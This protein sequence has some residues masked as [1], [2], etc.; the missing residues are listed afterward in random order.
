[1]YDGERVDDEDEIHILVHPADDATHEAS[2]GMMLGHFEECAPFLGH[3]Y[4]GSPACNRVLVRE[5]EAVTISLVEGTY[6]F[7]AVAGPFSTMARVG[8]VVVEAG[9]GQSVDLQL[10]TI[11]GLQPDGTLSGDFHIHARSSFDS[12]L[13]DEDRMRAVLASKI[14]VIAS[15]EHDSVFDFG[16]TLEDLGATGKVAVMN[17]TES[18]GHVLWY[19]NPT[20]TYPQVT[21]HWITWP[22]P[23]DPSQPWQGAPWDEQV[24]PGMLFTRYEE[25]GWDPE[26]GVIQLNHPVG[27]V[28]FG[29]DFGWASAML[30]S[31]REDLGGGPESAQSLFDR[32]PEGAAFAND[33]YHAQEVMN[34]TNNGQFL[35][36]RAYWHYLLNQ[37]EVRAGTANSDSHTLTDN[38]VGTPR[39]VVFTDTTLADFDEAS[40]N[41]SVREGRMFGTNGPVLLATLTD[42]GV[43]V[44][45]SS[46]VLEPSA[47]ASLD[48]EVRA[49]PWVDVQEVRVLVNGEIVETLTDLTPPPADPLSVPSS[50]AEL[51]RLQASLPLADLLPAQGDAWIS[52]EAGAPLVA[53]ADL[54]CDGWPDTGDTNGD[55]SIDWRDVGDGSLEEPPEGGCVELGGAGPLLDPPPPED[56]SSAAWFFYAVQPGAYPLAFTNPFVLDLDG[57]G[58][59]TGAAP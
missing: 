52:V 7:F 34:G 3:P 55:G 6:D 58:Q 9:T 19:F 48:I 38:V 46:D 5:G 50:P 35:Q 56:R 57:D 14:E 1:M 47:N 24:E 4:G 20:V 16:Q 23:Y 29:R 40:F 36:Y 49:A 53:N 33:D 51:L 12:S 26:N 17:G 27:G 13:P 32:Q 21:G 42:D 15:T 25:A 39:N 44:G 37:G 30:L 43:S 11:D 22:L 10:Q 28:Q 45:P 54:D 2:K 59:F 18:T 41:R 31:G 8:G